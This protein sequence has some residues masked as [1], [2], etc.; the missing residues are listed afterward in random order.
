MTSGALEKSTLET[1]IWNNFKKKKN[2]EA[3]QKELGRQAL[4]QNKRT[5]LQRSLVSDSI[6]WIIWILDEGVKS[7]SHFFLDKMVYTKWQGKI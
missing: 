5:K 1:L 7:V 4:H 6:T 3:A 2:Q